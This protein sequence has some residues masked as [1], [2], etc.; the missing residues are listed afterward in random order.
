MFWGAPRVLPLKDALEDRPE[1]PQ[2]QNRE[3]IHVTGMTLAGTKG[4]ALFPAS[5]TVEFGTGGRLFPGA[6]PLPS[7]SFFLLAPAS[8][9][10]ATCVT[11]S[12]LS[13]VPVGGGGI[14]KHLPVVSSPFVILGAPPTALPC[15]CAHR[16][17][18]LGGRNGTVALRST[19]QVHP[20]HRHPRPSHQTVP[21]SHMGAF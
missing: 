3:G 19:P 14:S 5:A 12:A 21:K 20:R 7:L 17:H 11:G 2:T 8:P 18:G 4:V 6:R 10:S 13:L 15:P 1:S 16:A 9:C